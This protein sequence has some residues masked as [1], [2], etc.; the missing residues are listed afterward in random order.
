MVDALKAT[1]KK[2]SK[3]KLSEGFQFTANAEHIFGQRSV[4]KDMRKV[5]QKGNPTE[6]GYLSNVLCQ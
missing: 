2:L 6:E 5:M 3:K 1:E 4:A